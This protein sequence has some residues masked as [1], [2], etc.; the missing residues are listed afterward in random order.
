MEKGQQRGT[1]HFFVDV[2]NTVCKSILRTEELN[3]YF[4][5]VASVRLYNN[6]TISLFL[7][8]I[9]KYYGK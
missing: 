3:F 2:F 7:C 5:S 6:F 1:Q 8:S 9:S 4:I